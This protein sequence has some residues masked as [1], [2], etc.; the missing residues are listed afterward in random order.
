MDAAFAS[1]APYSTVE[2]VAPALASI[3]I[4]N[5]RAG[6][7]EIHPSGQ[8]VLDIVPGRDTLLRRSMTRMQTLHVGSPCQH[9][10]SS[11]PTG[12]R[13]ALINVVDSRAGL[14]L[15]LVESRTVISNRL[16][17]K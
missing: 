8:E 11:F 6:L 16:H 1:T 12:L 3:S 10:Q 2:S 15:D 13:A 9:D 17:V 4:K 7:R 14:R 5:G